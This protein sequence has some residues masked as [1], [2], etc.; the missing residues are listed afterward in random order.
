MK[1]RKH[2]QSVQIGNVAVGGDN[3]VVVQSMTNTDTADTVRTT[4]Q[5]AELARAGSELV[6]ITAVSYTHLTLPTS[7]TV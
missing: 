1:L 2:S 6:R 5:I 7:Y 4:I 3:P